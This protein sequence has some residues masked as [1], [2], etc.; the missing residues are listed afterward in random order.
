MDLQEFCGSQEYLLPDWH[1][2][3]CVQFLNTPDLGLFYPIDTNIANNEFQFR[4]VIASCQY[5]STYDLLILI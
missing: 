1:L 3:L 2:F 4:L 5:V